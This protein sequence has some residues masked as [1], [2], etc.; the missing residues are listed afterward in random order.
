MPAARRVDKSAGGAG[1]RPRG[2]RKSLQIWGGAGQAVLSSNLRGQ[3]VERT[4]KHIRGGDGA[5]LLE[6]RLAALAGTKSG[7]VPVSPDKF[8]WKLALERFQWH[9]L[10]NPPKF[11]VR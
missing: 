2:L 4:G 10:H 9:H 3:V 11:S 6:R 5:W 8:V 7:T 1:S